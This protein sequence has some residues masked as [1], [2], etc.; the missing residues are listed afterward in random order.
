MQE[1][2]VSKVRQCA[3]FYLASQCSVRFHYRESTGEDWGK[4]ALYK[5]AS[6][7]PGTELEL[8]GAGLES[9]CTTKE[10]LCLS[11]DWTWKSGLTEAT[12]CLPNTFP[13]LSGRTTRLHFPSSFAVKTGSCNLI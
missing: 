7:E 5:M 11:Q 6:Q 9:Q 2:K 8:D 12:R 10:R 13:F 4:A 1:K 3:L